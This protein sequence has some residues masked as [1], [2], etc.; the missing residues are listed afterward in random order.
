MAT[1]QPQNR[2]NTT[3]APQPKVVKA[4]PANKL[5]GVLFTKENHKWMII[6]G[7]L[8]VLGYILMSGG[9]SS[10]PNQFNPSEVYSTLRITIAP[11]LILAGLGTL[12]YAI[13]RKGEK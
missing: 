8:V 4:K 6:G 11:V 3:N 2:P 7:A 10:D 12:V 13:M 5:A 9:K 1:V